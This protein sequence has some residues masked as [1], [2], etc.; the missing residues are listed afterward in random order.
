MLFNLFTRP[1]VQSP[2]LKK[3]KKIENQEKGVWNHID[4]YIY[5]C[6]HIFKTNIRKYKHICVYINSVCDKGS[7]RSLGEDRLFITGEPFREKNTAGSISP[8]MSK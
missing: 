2:V 5:L 1:W 3:K 8:L 4:K 6:T 7:F